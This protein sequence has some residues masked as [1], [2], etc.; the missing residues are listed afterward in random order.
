M[1]VTVTIEKQ[2]VTQRLVR[3]LYQAVGF[4]DYRAVLRPQPEQYTV[5]DINAL[6]AAQVPVAVAEWERLATTVDIPDADLDVGVPKVIPYVAPPPPP[7]LTIAEQ[8]EAARLLLE[9]V[10]ADVVAG[11]ITWDNSGTTYIVPSRPFDLNK[12]NLRV[13]TWSVERMVS[14]GVFTQEF[15][16]FTP[17]ELD[18]LAAAAAVFLDKCERAEEIVLLQIELGDFSVDFRAE[19]ANL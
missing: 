6:V 17:P 2:S 9:E 11:G 13:P 10:K 1:D 5:S 18:D 14:P 4:P 15:V 8:K 16:Q 3:A 19:L 12:L 7:P